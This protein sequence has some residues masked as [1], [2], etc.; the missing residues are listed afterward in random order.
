VPVNRLRDDH[1]VAE[2]DV[3]FQSSHVTRTS[4]PA[5]YWSK[6]RPSH[7]PTRPTVDRDAGDLVVDRA[8]RR[9]HPPG[10]GQR[11]LEVIE[12]TAPSLTV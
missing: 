11:L 8:R 3:P 1:D 5:T 7:A 9:T 4:R 6:T 2:Y 12:R 10:L